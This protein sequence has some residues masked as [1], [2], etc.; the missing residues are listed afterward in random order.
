MPSSPLFEAFVHIIPS[1]IYL[2][3]II[4]SGWM[5]QIEVLFEIVH[6]NSEYSHHSSI[7]FGVQATQ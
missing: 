7:H 3:G 4:A 6:H 2:L 1:Q 5:L